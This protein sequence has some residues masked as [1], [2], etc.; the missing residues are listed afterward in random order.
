MFMI[1][2]FRPLLNIPVVRNSI[3]GLQNNIT[4]ARMHRHAEEYLLSVFSIFFV[5][6]VT[7]FVVS[8]VLSI[9]FSYYFLLL[10]LTPIFYLIYGLLLP[11]HRA[12][13]RVKKL[14]KHMGEALRYLANLSVMNMTLYEMLERL[15]REKIYG[16]VSEEACELLY[17]AR[18]KSTEIFKVIEEYL[19]MTSEKSKWGMFLQGLVTVRKSGGVERDYILKA[20]ENYKNDLS[21][22]YGKLVE[23]LSMY[24]ELFITITVSFPLFLILIFAIMGIVSAPAVAEASLFYIFAVTVV[25]IPLTSIMLA[26]LIRSA[27]EG[28]E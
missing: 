24:A 12:N 2:R 28:Y 27:Q 14:D 1:N 18:L 16:I 23:Q 19:S 20:Y 3:P 9:L 25:M 21:I 13:A 8:L 17:T 26:W 15:C 11:K 4:V 5:S 7:V 22:E 6:F 10:S